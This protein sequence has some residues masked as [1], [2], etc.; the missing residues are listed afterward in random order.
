[1]CFHRRSKSEWYLLPFKQFKFIT[2][3][4][5]GVESLQF[6]KTCAIKV[7]FV[8]QERSND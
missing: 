3:L 1:M 5:F 2:I 8:S 6:L 4:F 7:D